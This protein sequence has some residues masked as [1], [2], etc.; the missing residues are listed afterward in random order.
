MRNSYLTIISILA[1]LLAILFLFLYRRQKQMR[2]AQYYQLHESAQQNIAKI[3]HQYDNIKRL[4]NTQSAQKKLYDNTLKSRIEMLNTLIELT[5]IYESR[6]NDFYDKCRSYINMCNKNETSFF[7]DIRDIACLYVTDFVK[8]L[9]NQ[10]PTLSDE[11]INLCC[12]TLLGFDI[13]HIR[14]LF[15]H[16]NIQSTYSKRTRLRKKLGLNSDENIRN[17]LLSLSTK[18]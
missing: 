12:L 16:S 7:N 11:E 9:Q 14:I 15:N 17:F 3:Q 18:S 2:I 6:K 8:T 10:F 1:L 4:L 13:N 5:D